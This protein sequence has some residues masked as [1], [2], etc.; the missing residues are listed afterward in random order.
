MYTD[1]RSGL[2]VPLEIP[3]HLLVPM[4]VNLLIRQ[5]QVPSEQS[6]K[7]VVANSVTASR[8]RAKPMQ[9]FEA[10]IACLENPL[11]RDD[12]GRIEFGLTLLLLDVVHTL[13]VSTPDDIWQIDRQNR[14]EWFKWVRIWTDPSR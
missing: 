14:L 9:A 3:L 8:L 10:L 4:Q 6:I 5:L 7:D 11:P 13:G 1:V 2:F 12:W